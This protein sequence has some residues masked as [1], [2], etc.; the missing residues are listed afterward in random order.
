MTLKVTLR[1]QV[2]LNYGL[3]LAAWQEIEHLVGTMGKEPDTSR[4]TLMMV[5]MQ[6]EALKQM[7]P[8]TKEREQ[9]RAWN[10]AGV[11]YSNDDLWSPEAWK[12]WYG[13]SK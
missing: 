4:A 10:L 7:F 13:P 1:A 5:G 11:L 2:F 8:S 3:G 12:A 6:R 9:V